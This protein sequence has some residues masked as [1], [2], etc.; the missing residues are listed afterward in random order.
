MVCIAQTGNNSNVHQLVNW[1]TSYDVSIQWNTLTT[2]GKLLICAA[3]WM[4]WIILWGERSQTVKSV[5]S[6]I[7]FIL[8]SGKFRKWSVVTKSRSLVAWD[9][10][11][12]ARAWMKRLP[13]DTRNLLGV[14]KVFFC[15]DYSNDF[16][17]VY[18]YIYIYTHTHT[19]N[20]PSSTLSLCI[21]YYM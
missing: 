13:R 6:V 15:L 17:G 9:V 7:Q 11:E 12:V 21:I 20:L 8:N 18:I 1:E 5:H 19:Q 3:T 2:K 14:M 4:K 16:V 10:A